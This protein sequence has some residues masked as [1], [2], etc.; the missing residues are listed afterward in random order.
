[1]TKDTTI[2]TRTYRIPCEHP[3]YLALCWK[4]ILA[5]TAAA[6]GIHILLFLLGT[7]GGLTLFTP[8]TDTDP[9]AHFSIGA[10]FVWS[11]CA[12]VAVFF[13][14]VIAGRFSNSPH[15]GFAHGI[16]VWSLT[17][18]IAL[19]IAVMGTGRLTAGATRVLGD[20]KNIVGSPIS[21]V[22]KENIILWNDELTSFVTEVV[23]A[24]ANDAESIATRREL[25]L[26]VRRMF[27]PG[28]DVTSKDN[29]A[30]VIAV[31]AGVKRNPEA[32]VNRW[33]AYHQNL[34]AER[35]VAEQRARVQ[36]EEA[37]GN[38][39]CVAILAFFALLVGLVAAALGGV[40]GA[41]CALR[42]VDEQF[43]RIG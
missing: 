40:C 6:M 22:M 41:K 2:S 33:I 17:L 24:D 21:E 1:M 29:R 38:L 42:H 39:A 19:G 25:T 8:V 43:S 32:T 7:A 11:V 36:A 27:G 9:V 34:Q 13:G 16:L 30:A 15:S 14:G 3:F 12:I 23:P 4:A 28:G 10:A 18:I 35:R 20:R 37:A 26:A 5:G 31:L